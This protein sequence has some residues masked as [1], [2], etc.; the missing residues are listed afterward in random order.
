VAKLRNAGQSCIAANRIYV[1]RPI[2]AEFGAAL[3]ARLQAVKIGREAS[4]GPMIDA[5]ARAH[6][7]EL[8]DSALSAGGDLLTGGGTVERPGYY[9]E[10]TLVTGVKASEP[11]LTEEVFGPACALVEFD[12]EEEAIELANSVSTGLV[13]YVFCSGLDRVLRLADELDTGMVGVNRGVVSSAAAPFG[14]T[15]VSGL[16]REGGEEGLREYQETK[17]VCIDSGASTPR[18]RTGASAA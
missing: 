15:K 8:V 18:M 3:A 16:G 10:P 4:L 11:L 7:A 5:P 6:V 13:A 2:A 14:G 12:G 9:Y 1:E 17:Y